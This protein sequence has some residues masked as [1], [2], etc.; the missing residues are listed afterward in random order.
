MNITPITHFSGKLP[1]KHIAHLKL[2]GEEITMADVYKSVG[3]IAQDR[4]GLCWDWIPSSACLSDLRLMR[5][6]IR[7]AIE[8]SKPATSLQISTSTC[9]FHSEDLTQ[10][11]LKHMLSC[12]N[13]F[14]TDLHCLRPESRR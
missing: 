6:L 11:Q 5:S 1:F 9:S 7:K 13:S 2:T 14:I 12:T 4:Y 3:Y 10:K 8:L